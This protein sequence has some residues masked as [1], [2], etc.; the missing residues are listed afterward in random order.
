[1]R[2]GLCN[3]SIYTLARPGAYGFGTWRRCGRKVYRRNLC[4]RCW[5]WFA[6]FIFTGNPKTIGRWLEQCIT[7]SNPPSCAP[8]C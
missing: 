3:E 4:L 8:R 6:A 1:M 5:R 2:E 7:R